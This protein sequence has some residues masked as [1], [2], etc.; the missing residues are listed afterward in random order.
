MQPPSPWKHQMTPMSLGDLCEVQVGRPPSP[1]AGPGSSV[2]PC[3][4]ADHVQWDG[5]DLA[6]VEQV[7]LTE[8]E[9]GVYSLRSG[10]VLVCAVHEPGRA[11]VWEENHTPCCF[12]DSLCRLRSDPAAVHPKYLVFWLRNAIVNE[13][14]LDS[15]RG[16]RSAFLP[17][18]QLSDL[19]IRLPSLQGQ[20]RI[21]DS[22][23]QN[24]SALDR[25][26]LELEQLC[27]DCSVA[28]TAQ[29]DW[30]YSNYGPG[31]WPVMPLRDLLRECEDSLG[32]D[33]P[34]SASETYVG[35][36]Q[37]E[38]GT[39]RTIHQE[40]I[41][42]NPIPGLV[43]RF[44]Y[45]DLVVGAIHP[46]EGKV[47]IANCTGI[48]SADQHVFEV[49]S[50]TAVAEY[51]ARFMRS[52]AFSNQLLAS[53]TI[54]DGERIESETILNAMIPIHDIEVQW[55]FL[56]WLDY[57]IQRIERL[58]APFQR[59]LDNLFHYRADILRRAFQGMHLRA[60]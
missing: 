8:D 59:E 33:C 3:L 14:I 46:Y 58:R 15:T 27:R 19:R 13:Q 57:R 52:R 2:L 34:P 39:G 43:R 44:R 24:L 4:R 36:E 47:W 6:D 51:V 18:Q 10:D 25:W 20:V 9:V 49:N 60:M 41:S 37:I 12:D 45:G 42:P 22:V 48:C 23:S 38:S 54:S 40:T 31:A 30:S 26:N 55:E 21:V 53:G 35:L 28:S 29:L 16:S 56:N 32:P 11:A 50:H 7:S 1:K 5:L 17:A